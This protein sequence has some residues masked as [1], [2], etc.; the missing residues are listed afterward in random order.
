MTHLSKPFGLI[1]C[2][3]LAGA[4]PMAFAQATPPAEPATPVEPA[5]PAAPVTSVDDMGLTMGQEAD[6]GVGTPYVSGT[7]DVWEQ[8]CVRTEDGSDPCQLYQLLKDSSGNAVAEFSVF[9]LPAG[10]EAVAGATIIV[11]LETLLTE[12]IVMQVDS[13]T[14]VIYPFTFC[15][16][17][18]C[19]ARVGFTA[20]QVDAFRKGAAAKITIVPAIAPDEQVTVN[21]SLKGFTA[22]F[23]AVAA[24]TLAA[25]RP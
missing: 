21:V 24:T 18:G 3:A 12:N 15:S 6:G 8:R 19:V 10:N 7:F 11:P 23:A 14:P 16:Q 25:P 22:G 20:A 17:I 2:L 4:A 5:T 9:G 13:G 1:L